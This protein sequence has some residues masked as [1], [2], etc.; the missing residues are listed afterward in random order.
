[1]SVPDYYVW[2]QGLELVQKTAKAEAW[3]ECLGSFVHPNP[4]IDFEKCVWLQRNWKS[5]SVYRTW[6]DEKVLVAKE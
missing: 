1:M 2:L 6:V 4:Y 3:V 5:G